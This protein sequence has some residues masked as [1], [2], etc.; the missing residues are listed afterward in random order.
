MRNALV[1]VLLLLLLGAP[2]AHAASPPLVRYHA[3]QAIP[4]GD[5]GL[6]VRKDGTAVA[7]H[8]ANR[9]PFALT[10]TQLG[11]LRRL[12]RRA[13]FDTLQPRYAQPEGPPIV[14]GRTETVRSAGK[15]VVAEPGARIPARLD[16]LLQRLRRT[17][18]AHDPGA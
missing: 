9:K 5:W 11:G 13:H 2:A 17:F 18:A 4:G 12:V 15:K 16:R 1:A 14:G 6:L 8:M 10:A 3:T 7:R